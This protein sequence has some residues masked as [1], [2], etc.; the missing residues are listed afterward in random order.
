VLPNYVGASADGSYI[1]FTYQAID[2][3][4]SSSVAGSFSWAGMYNPGLGSYPSYNSLMSYEVS[5]GELHLVSH[6][7]FTQGSGV[8]PYYYS[9]QSSAPTLLSTSADGR[10]ALVQG[11]N[12][13]LGNTV[14]GSAYS[15]S[16]T[17]N[18]LFVYDNLT[19]NMR[20]VSHNNAPYL[21]GADAASYYTDNYGYVFSSPAAMSFTPDSQWVLFNGNNISQLGNSSNVKLFSDAN[22]SANDIVA[23]NLATQQLN[24][25]T[26]S[27]VAGNQASALTASA[28]LN[29]ISADSKYVVFT[30]TNAA[31]LGNAGQAF[32][33]SSPGTANL[34]AYN[35]ASGVTTLISHSAALSNGSYLSTAGAT[36]GTT[37]SVFNALT[38]D[39][40]YVIFT[41]N[42]AG[43]FGSNGTYLSDAGPAAADLFAYDLA[44][45]A[46]RLLSHDSTAGNL[47]SSAIYSSSYAGTSGDGR[48]VFFTQQD[49][50][51]LG[52]NG[53]SFQ[54]ANPK[55]LDLFAYDLRTGELRL[56]DASAT[57]LG[58][59]GT[60]ASVSYQGSSADG[61]YAVFSVTD[62]GTLGTVDSNGTGTAFSTSGTQ[63]VLVRL[64]LLDLATD[65]GSS[66]TDNL[67]NSGTLTLNAAVNPN[68]QVKLVD[69][70]T[71]Q[72]TVYTADANGKVVINLTGVTAG[73][74]TYSLVD[75]TSSAPLTLAYGVS[76]GAS[77][78]V[79][80]ATSAPTTP[81]I[82]NVTADNKV[83]NVE[84]TAGVSI[85]GT[86][87]PYARL[88]V[89]WD[90]AAAQTT[91]ADANGNWSVFYVQ[92]QVPTDNASSLITAVATDAAGN[93]ATG[94]RTIQVNTVGP[95][96]PYLSNVTIGSGSATAFTTGMAITSTSA[97]VTL[98]G[99]GPNSTAITINW[100]GQVKTVTS[101]AGGAWTATFNSA[102]VAPPNQGG[103]P[104]S[105]TATDA[106]GNV[107]SI[108]TYQA[109]VNT[110]GSLWAGNEAL[111]THTGTWS[112]ASGVVQ[113][114][115]RAASSNV[116][117]YTS[118]GYTYN[119]Y[120]N[121]GVLG[122]GVSNLLAFTAPDPS[123]YG[124]SV[125]GTATPFA[126]TQTANL[127]TLVNAAVGNYTVFSIML[128]DPVTQGLKLVNHTGAQYYNNTATND[129]MST[130]GFT[131]DGAYY[132]FQKMDITQLG[133]YVGSTAT[134]F[135][136]ASGS[137]ASTNSATAD[138]LAYSTSTGTLSLVTHNAVAGGMQSS[139]TGSNYLATS[140]DGRFVVFSGTAAQYGN[141][142]VSFSSANAVNDLFAYNLATGQQRLL[143]HGAASALASTTTAG[144]S[145]NALTPDGG[146]AVF[147]YTNM[148]QLGNGRQLFTDQYTGATDI[149]L[150]NL[151]TGKQTLVTHSALAG[152]ADSGAA[153]GSTYQSTNPTGQYLLFTNN[154]ASTFGN[155]GVSF[156]DSATATADALVYNI[157]TG[158]LQLVTH[159]SVSG[160]LTSSGVPGSNFVW[161]IDG[162]YLAF[163]A[164]NAGAFGNDGTGFVDGTSGID[165]VMLYQLSTGQLSLV[166]HN[167]NAGNLG[168]S[169]VAA[170]SGAQFSADGKYLVFSDTDVTQ[171]GN[172][173]SLFTQAS[174]GVTQ[175]VAYNTSTGALGLITHG[176]A[177][178]NGNSQSSASS[179]LQ[180]ISADGQY[181]IFSNYNASQFGNGGTAFTDA[182]PYSSGT[183]LFAYNLSTGQTDL[184]THSALAGRT[185][186]A[187]L[188][189][190]TYNGMTADGRYVI[191]SSSN[192]DQANYGNYGVAFQGSYGGVFAYDLATKELRPLHLDPTTL[193]QT[194]YSLGYSA[195][196]PDGNYVLL[197]TG[198]AQYGFAG[199][200]ASGTAF[201]DNQPNTDLITVRLNLLDL[202]TS[203]DNG[204]SAVDN[205][206][207]LSSLSLNGQVRP[208]QAVKLMDSVN[209]GSATQVATGTAD[210]TGAV[211]FNLTGV[212]TGQHTY[213]LTDNSGNPIVEYLGLTSGATLTV[214]V[215][216]NNLSTPTINPVGTA[217]LVN[218][219]QIQTGVTVS[220][221]AVGASTV[222]VSWGTGSQKASVDSLGNWSML[223]SGSNIPQDGT[224]TLSAVSYDAAGFPS[225]AGTLAG[226]V[227]NATAPGAVTIA[228]LNS[229]NLVDAAAAAAGV[230]FSGTSDANAT[231]KVKWGTRTLATT[232]NGSGAWSVSF[233]AAQ[234]PQ[235]GLG[236][237]SVTATNSLG[238]PSSAVLTVGV[239]ASTLQVSATQLLTHSA[240]A[241]S[242]SAITD[243]LATS[244]GAVSVSADGN[245]TLF[246]ATDL[247]HLGNA[248][249]AFSSSASVANLM[250]YNHATGALNLVTHNAT[251]TS[252][253]YLNAS[254]TGG[255]SSYSLS[256]S[257]QYV[258]FTAANAASFGNSGVSFTDTGTAANDVL[259][260][261]LGSGQISL[262]TH[263]SLAGN[264]Q[265]SSSSASTLAGFTGNSQYLVFNNA[266]ATAFG[267]GGTAFT[268]LS[269]SFT[270]I[271]AYNLATGQTSLVTHDKTVGNGTTSATSNSTVDLVNS[272]SNGQWLLFNN[273]NAAAFG[274]N[275]TAFTD[276]G[277]GST[278]LFA[279]NLNTGNTALVTH[280]AAVGNLQS[281]AVTTSAAVGVSTDSRYLAFSNSNAVTFG[282]AGT[283]FTD[284]ATANTDYL[285]YEFSTGATR[286]IT[287]S[288][289]NGGGDSGLLNGS[290]SALQMGSDGRYLVFS[291][292]DVS[293]LGNNGQTFVDSASAA[294]DLVVYDLASGQLS[295]ASHS[296]ALG[297]ATSATA[298]A[299]S[300]GVW[301][302][303]VVF[304][305]ADASKFGNG[306]N[307]FAD[308]GTS[309]TDLFTYNAVS[310]T[311]NLVTHSATNTLSSNQSTVTSGANY[312]TPD[313]RFIVFSAP[314]ATRFG[315]NGVSFTDASVTANDLF[316]YEVAT[317]QIRLMTHDGS[318]GALSSSL[319][320]G[321][322]FVGISGDSR[323][324]FFT[325]ADAST[326]GNNGANFTD[327]QTA[328][329]DLFA[330]D[331]QSGELR[332]IDASAL[333]M[334]ATGAAAGSAVASA[335]AYIASNG[336]FV[337]FT[338]A[339]LGNL[340]TGASGAGTA[341]TD[342]ITTG[343]DIVSVRMNLLSLAA[344]DDTAPTYGAAQ[345]VNAASINGGAALHD[346]VTSKTSFTL[347]AAVNASEQVTLL[348]NG[349]STGLTVTAD[350][351][352]NAT[353]ALSGVTTGVHYYSLVD[354]VS[355]KPL[356]LVPGLSSG[357]QLKLTVQ[358]S[359]PTA[360]TINAIANNLI[361]APGMNAGVLVTGTAVGA[362]VVNVTLGNT[363][364]AAIVN[365]QGNWSTRFT[366]SQIP[367]DGTTSISAVAQD[368]A[369]NLSQ[370]STLGGI[371]VT[372]VAPMTPVI[373]N[374]IG[375]NNVVNAAVKTAGFT[376]AGTADANMAIKLSWGATTKNTTTDAAG[377]WSFNLTTL[378]MPSDGPS[379]LTVT[380]TTAVGN[381]ASA[382]QTV[383]M[384][385]MGVTN[386]YM[387]L[388]THNAVVGF[389]ATSETASSVWSN[390]LSVGADSQTVVFG[391][392]NAS[393]F[394][395]AGASLTDSLTAATDLMVY[396]IRTGAVQ[397]VTHSS[398]A[399]T[400][401]AATGNASLVAISADSSKVL[402]SETAV[403]GLG[404][405]GTDFI[406]SASTLDYLVYNVGTG[407]TQLVTHAASSVNTN[408]VTTSA[409]GTITA[410]GRNVI[411]TNVDASQFGNGSAFADAQTGVKDILAYNVATG[412]HSLV[413]HSGVGNG[414]S[415]LTTNAVFTASYV[416][417]DGKYVAFAAPNAAQ[418][419][420]AGSGGAFTEAGSATANDVFVYNLSTGMLQLATHTAASQTT[421]ADTVGSTFL[422]Y[423]GD[424]K[425]LLFSNSD[426]SSFGNGTGAFTDSLI[427]VTDI[428]SYELATGNTELVTH[429][430]LAGNA[431]SSALT[432]AS[433]VGSTAD[434]LYTV[435]SANDATGYGNAGLAFSDQTLGVQDYLAYN[436]GTQQ[437][438]LITHSALPGNTD[439]AGVVSSNLSFSADGSWAF[440][441]A[442]NAGAFGN[443]GLAFSESS[444]SFTNTS[445]LFA[446]DFSNGHLT[447]L[448]H[449]SNAGNA[450]SS[451]TATT[452]FNWSNGAIAVF[453]GIDATQFGNNGT[454][455]VD[456]A[457]SNND[458]FVENLNT[459]VVQLVTHSAAAGN[460]V[461][462]GVATSYVGASANGQYVFFTATDA[463]KF[464]NNGT[465]FVDVNTAATDLFAYD[466]Q[467]GEVRLMDASATALNTTGTTSG[468][469]GFGGV[470]ADNST[471]FFTV[472][473]LG[474]MGN[475]P[476]SGTAYTAAST[477]ATEVVSMRLNLLALDSASDNGPSSSDNVTSARNLTLH[478]L[479]QPSQSVNL[480]DQ[481]SQSVVATG[482]ANA[483]G[484]VDFT[485]RNVSAGLHDYTLVDANNSML[486]MSWGLV[487]G[488]HLQVTVLG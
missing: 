36:G 415:Q 2:Q 189:N 138:I 418:L 3:L 10:Y 285:L 100:A 331:L 449:N 96:T 282:Y 23:Y 46:I 151:A 483:N 427:A 5:T 326:L 400:A 163:T 34:F 395:T 195:L 223:F 21:T 311:I 125:S 329:N 95:A 327:A 281:A 41:A 319:Q 102:G 198:Y 51:K 387:R 248:G 365:S 412:Q 93:T 56:L 236:S 354:S 208:S 30:A 170:A 408:A 259:V 280:S 200:A 308:A 391:N 249:A 38:A 306:G 25:V 325:A 173:G 112:A 123:V 167:A 386:A 45:G 388:V 17:A 451:V 396:N 24:L 32:S 481:W 460:L 414:D 486:T 53:A 52:N 152:N 33:D 339:N 58:Q 101:T 401:S 345:A 458:I 454:A 15:F 360:P 215:V 291:A 464:G 277:T 433:Y 393:Q 26:H 361:N 74:H 179:T 183:D 155:N 85:S 385:A 67:T 410:D 443:N 159:S 438:T 44:T 141:A 132:L 466:T 283:A 4:G 110:S 172:N 241:N 232:A 304:S 129:A 69:G 269:T 164:A 235:D 436:F 227:V 444:S 158:N 364:L 243:T 76:S 330:Y 135:S 98:T 16:N 334:G 437:T 431:N 197:N 274:N 487:S 90:T 6:R 328:V 40:K 422:G 80:V 273:L 407:T 117:S 254:Q 50:T 122:F 212:S 358:T 20:L 216:A 181:A 193:G 450:A 253:A 445:N 447:L 86:A 204:S 229:G 88:N 59:A 106:I 233:T 147:S 332:L 166:T 202:A 11:L 367:A 309:T 417:P 347:K 352:G 37:G 399:N 238:N 275:G 43:K 310:G 295:L 251:L 176:A 471:A 39:G 143:T 126:N 267:N 476:G 219:N 342:A 411:F 225:Q 94:T 351:N 153:V 323:Y 301:G 373:G 244:L 8:N 366:G 290:A 298:A 300:Y 109:V 28:V 392:P 111:V 272:P 286:L 376:V 142:G 403:T 222:V 380:A 457:T 258:A 185:E 136:R 137:T 149:V 194:A 375:T 279:Y 180:G 341:F 294:S 474:T 317:G 209:G 131:A 49:A 292:S 245:F 190:V 48:Y 119:W 434:G 99:T 340:G 103:T 250:A 384:A 188:S 133:N 134:A 288:A 165:D 230:S 268:D 419:G 206:T 81:V 320:A 406:N 316:V 480:F 157:N 312:V 379:T 240:A 263:S 242:S 203:S 488:S 455:F 467:T 337:D 432:S 120:E 377:N 205:V 178:G 118:N 187:H 171:L 199:P 456:G 270:D 313:G 477:S 289:A 174:T 428:L 113:A 271:F 71:V 182:N 87:S 453:S 42:N 266:N 14:G 473:N 104:I 97:G 105:L 452:S 382:S 475:Y 231:V 479:V 284:N 446:Y 63:L 150:A 423:S 201:S 78:S 439:S 84:K 66:A 144:V 121:A 262:A 61:N 54:D 191:F 1:Y 404:N 70:S 234:V 390:Q 318:S 409:D 265:A 114:G 463:S 333:V 162:K 107:S 402:F 372:T 462:S 257:G 31:L 368:L 192:G 19:G 156:T 482:T 79:T 127:A 356:T 252:G 108:N 68:Q 239:N 362:S 359:A 314:D 57:V 461:S 260:Y 324:V 429:S 64:N 207:N 338:T 348:D 246:Y 353:F 383:T 22:T 346:N 128:Y 335:S 218:Y 177:V 370:A 459:G 405:S 72:S 441:N 397:L 435:F 82:G 420:N 228:N 287:H 224:Y 226:V 425:Y 344:A 357:A 296:A 139:D 211:N 13:A 440:F 478:G 416:S 394:G 169:L 148:L 220:G 472:A 299:T 485:L 161:S 398:A 29:G 381:V 75:A 256:A 12:G 374:V 47:S 247:S 60:G 213:S 430:S 302:E 146:Y 303:T 62:T 321:A 343:A 369:G 55:Q 470:T 421:S 264:A 214:K 130:R 448:T 336:N 184:I 115:Y 484:E 261:N 350:A 371:L 255:V 89:T 305:A 349:S 168:S 186:S 196:S 426:V 221:T 413:T 315:N 465:A 355:G 35:L 65:S 9:Y 116:Y 18:S 378:D 145:Y 389:A 293:S 73:A 424:G 468:V 27:S 140:G 7:Y 297:S 469:L 217:S 307:A 442:G 91:T 154:N 278:D 363:T 175:W 83:N 92:A 160:N 124:N 276:L 210:A 77:I 237:V 322:T